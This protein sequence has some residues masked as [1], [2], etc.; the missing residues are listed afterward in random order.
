VFPCWI[1]ALLSRLAKRMH[2][3]YVLRGWAKEHPTLAERIGRRVIADFR[4]SRN[5]KATFD[6]AMTRVIDALKSMRP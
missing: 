2:D 5:D 6:R 1:Y 4:H 3:D